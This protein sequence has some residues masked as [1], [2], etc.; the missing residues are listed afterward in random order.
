M[1]LTI[2]LNLLESRRKKAH[3]KYLETT[4]ARVHGEI[5]SHVLSEEHKNASNKAILF[6]KYCRRLN[7]ISI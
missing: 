2:K 1:G 6:K 4:I 3:K 5:V 7:Y